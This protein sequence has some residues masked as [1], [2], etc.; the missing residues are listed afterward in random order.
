MPLSLIESAIVSTS[1][2]RNGA[3]YT[4]RFSDEK[5]FLYT[6]SISITDF[7]DNKT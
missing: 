5:A 4:T 1:V 7:T 3:Q 6:G 2:L